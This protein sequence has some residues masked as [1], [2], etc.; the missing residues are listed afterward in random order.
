MG[1]RTELSFTWA[2]VASSVPQPPLLLSPGNQSNTLGTPVQ[3]A[4]RSRE[5]NG[6][7]VSFAASGLPPGLALNPLTGRISGTPTI[8]GSY[9]VTVNDSDNKD[10][11]TKARILWL[12]TGQT[13]SANP[14]TGL[15]YEYFEGDWRKVPKFDK[16]SPLATGIARKIDLAPRRRNDRFALRYTGMLRLLDAGVYTFYLAADAASKLWIDGNVLINN[17][18]LHAPKERSATVSLGAGEHAIQ[19][20]YANTNTANLLSVKVAGPGLPKH[21]LRSDMLSQPSTGLTYEYYEGVWPVLP[22]FN[23]LTARKRGFVSLIDLAP[24]LRKDH[25][26]LRFRGRLQLARNEP[27]TFYLQADTGG[28]V[29]IDGKP[30]VNR[31]PFDATEVT[32]TRWLSAGEHELTVGYFANSGP[33]TLNLSY[34]TPTVRKRPLTTSMLPTD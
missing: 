22:N 19:V 17:D 24:G 4:L 30:V 3:L 16:L 20:A 27:Y 5:M 1:S 8:P 13:D 33:K 23:K 34:S 18:G 10:G 28:R 14:G 2:I 11:T 9:F 12:I 21:R 7:P 31:G 25:F 29:W 6:E 15:V 32:G 26:G